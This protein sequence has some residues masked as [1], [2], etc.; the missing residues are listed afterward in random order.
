VYNLY[1]GDGH[2]SEKLG[3][4]KKREDDITGEGGKR[5]RSREEGGDVCGGKNKAE[6]KG[7][8]I[9]SKGEPA[10]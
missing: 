7:S 9:S 3:L 1:T 8:R 10:L 5:V 2:R 4:R 6:G